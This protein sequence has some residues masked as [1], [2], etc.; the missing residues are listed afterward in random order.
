MAK[1]KAKGKQERVGL[2]DQGWKEDADHVEELPEGGFSENFGSPSELLQPNLSPEDQDMEMQPV[3]VGPGAYA[4]PDP[5]TNSGRLRSIENHPLQDRISEDYGQDVAG[6]TV[7]PGETHPGE[8][9][10]LEGDLQ[11]DREA[12]YEEMTK[13]ELLEMAADREI[14]G[15][16]DM[17]K[18]ELV[19]AHEAYDEAS[20]GPE[21]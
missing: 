7:E 4:S 8:P 17:S 2:N 21:S 12:S 18:A 19:K 1:A 10:T 6:A 15:R 11:G 14:E 9:G 16:S 13:A 20:G 5:A 3:I